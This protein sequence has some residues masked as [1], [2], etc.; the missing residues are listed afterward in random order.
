M[1]AW[2]INIVLLNLTE[3]SSEVL[4]ERS[5]HHLTLQAVFLIAII[6]AG[7]VSELQALMAELPCELIQ[8]QGGVETSSYVHP[9]DGLGIPFELIS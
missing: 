1:L 9:E 2:D 8:R 6:L 5:L 4:S 3:P 7:K